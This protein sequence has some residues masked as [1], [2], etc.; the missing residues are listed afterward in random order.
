MEA[1]SQFMINS[2]KSVDLQINRTLLYIEDFMNLS[3]KS[4]KWYY[5]FIIHVNDTILLI[6]KEA[7]LIF[8]KPEPQK[9]TFQFSVSSFFLLCI[10]PIDWFDIKNLLGLSGEKYISLKTGEGL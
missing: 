1:D 10:F 4:C 2:F 7:D 3:S 8:F 6:E 5:I 9:I